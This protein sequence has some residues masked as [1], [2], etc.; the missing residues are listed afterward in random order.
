MTEVTVEKYSVIECER[1]FLLADVPPGALEPRRITDLYLDGTR[2]RLR[3]VTTPHGDVLERK[4]GHKRRY[5][6]SDPSVVLH[7]SMYLDEHEFETLSALPGRTLT[8][9]RWTMH[10]ADRRGAVD[11]FE[12]DLFGLAMLEVDL[13]DPDEASAYE[14]PLVGEI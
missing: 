1:R 6:E 7:T 2:L 5:D 9:T 10:L 4:L 14:P 12:K 13:S 11:V 8:K 3:S